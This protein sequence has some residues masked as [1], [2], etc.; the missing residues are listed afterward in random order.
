MAYNGIAVSRTAPIP[1]APKPP[2][3]EPAKYQES[4]RR[5]EIGSVG[6]H[7][8]VSTDSPSVSASAPAS[9]QPVPPCRACQHSRSR[10]I[11]SEDD[12]GC[13]PCQVN[14]TDCSL[15]SSTPSPGS[16]KRKLNGR[17]H[18]ISTKRRFVLITRHATYP[19]SITSPSYPSYNL[20]SY[21]PL[22][23]HPLPT[24]CSPLHICGS[25]SPRIDP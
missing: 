11:P 15:S 2:R 7:P 20:T 6:L 8:R 4:P 14:A 5:F 24:T 12:D 22:Y 21:S 3:P 19:D 23:L 9:C 1:I 18:E 13:I 25:E 16:R 10:C 17:V